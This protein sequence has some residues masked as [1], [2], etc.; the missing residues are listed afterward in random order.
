MEPKPP[1]DKET[2][3][4]WQVV[5]SVAASMFGVQSRANRERDFTR[6]KAVHFIVIG[7]VMVAAFVGTLVIVVKIL[8]RKAGL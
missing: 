8:L 6:G 1:Q 7:L 4:L 5:Q 3:G 2:V